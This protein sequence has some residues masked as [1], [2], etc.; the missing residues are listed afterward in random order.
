MDSLISIML[1]PLVACLILTGIHTYLGLHVVSRGV[2]FVDLALAQI[3]ALGSTF[4]FLLGFDPKS[5]AGYLYSLGFAFLGA[6]VFSLSRLKDKRVPQEALIGIT[7]AVASSAAILIADR[8]PQGAEHVKEMLT[9][10]ILWITWPT[11][12]KTLAI[13]VAIGLFHFLFRQKF[14]LISM[15]PEEAE[16]RGIAVRWWDFLF[17]M[18]FGFVITSSVAIAGVLLVFSFLIIPSVIGMLYSTRI[19]SRL[20]I[21]WASGMLVSLLGLYLSYDF[22]FPSGPSIV[23]SFG[24]FLVVSALIRY[25]ALAQNCVVA[26]AKTGAAALALTSLLILALHFRPVGTQSEARAEDQWEQISQALQDLSSPAGLEAPALDLLKTH[27]E[28]FQ[29]GLEEG[30]IHFDQR[31]VQRMGELG[32]SDLI[33]FVEGIVETTRDPWMKYYAAEALL[34]LGD[35]G[36][37]HHLISILGRQAPVFLKSR[38]IGKLRGIIGEDFDFDPMKSAQENEKPINQLEVWWHQNSDRLSWDPKRQI[39]SSR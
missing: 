8:A 21:G 12:W 9:G 14:L 10:S 29:K 31:A 33:P 23:C 39:F 7:F 6:A 28:V 18:S 11:I 3:A 37:I 36:G 4:A 34:R 22:D 2:I 38:A 15:Q 16:R 32:D 1:P 19:G 26:L 24:A 20:M 35:K 13:Y 5:P 17:Y 25:L 27:Q 30:L